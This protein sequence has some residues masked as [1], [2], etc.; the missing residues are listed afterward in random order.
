LIVVIYVVGVV[1]GAMLISSYAAYRDVKGEVYDVADSIGAALVWPLIIVAAIAVGFGKLYWWAN[2]KLMAWAV[3]LPP[4]LAQAREV[5]F[6]PQ[7]TGAEIDA[8]LTARKEQL[9]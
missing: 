1:I 8:E 6:P 5:W 9:Q 7:P 2:L 4:R 3:S